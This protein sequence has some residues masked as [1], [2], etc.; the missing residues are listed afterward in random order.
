MVLRDGRFRMPEAL[1]LAIQGITGGPVWDRATSTILGLEGEEHQRRR[2]VAKAFGPRS[3]ERLRRNMVE[4]INSLVDEISPDG[5][6]DVVADIARRYPTPV[7]CD[8]LG[9]PRQDSPQLAA[10]S[11]DIFKLLGFNVTADTPDILRAFSALDAYVDTLVDARRDHLTDDLLSDLIRAEEEGDRLSHAELRM[12]VGAILAAGTDTTCSQL[13]A[14]A[15]VFA[16]HPDQ[17]EVLAREPERPSAAVDEV[18]RHSPVVF[19]T[20]RVA[21]EDVQLCGL[22]IPAGTLVTANTSADNRDP[23]VF[24][25]PDT[26]DI[27]RVP[28]APMLT[29]GEGRSPLS[30]GPFGQD[31]AGR[32]PGG[33][34]PWKPVLGI[35]GPS[36]LSVEFDPDQ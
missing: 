29:F 15:Q 14:A 31:G 12:M 35:S 10:W 3:I 1:G 22:I 36:A 17:W 34:A 2:L 21:T 13:A 30:W 7:V 18:M 5:R 20:V 8:L 32:G 27:T 19:G 23:A 6:C 28:A 16:D 4:V 33:P 26:F 9:A 11:D 25:A 24:P